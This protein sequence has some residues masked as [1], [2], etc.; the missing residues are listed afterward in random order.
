MAINRTTVSGAGYTTASS[1]GSGLGV[2]DIPIAVI[3]MVLQA[4]AVVKVKNVFFMVS[5]LRIGLLLF[6]P[7]RSMSGGYYILKSQQVLFCANL[8]RCTKLGLYKSAHDFWNN[9]ALDTETLHAAK[10]HATDSVFVSKKENQHSS[11]DLSTRAATSC[12]PYY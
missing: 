8:N 11:L 12:T 4:S 10:L 1:T 3:A 6:F 5:S 2:F 9:K 7:V